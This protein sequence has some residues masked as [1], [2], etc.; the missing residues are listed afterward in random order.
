MRISLDAERCARCK[1]CLRVGENY[2][3][4]WMDD[5][6]YFDEEVCNTC[7]KC[8]A[9]C[10]FQ[11]IVVDGHH[12]EKIAERHSVTADGFTRLLEQRRSTKAFKDEAVPRELL[13]RIAGAAKFS[14]NQNKNISIRIITDKELIREIDRAAIGFVKTMHG[15]LFGCKAVTALIR[16]F[17]R[18]IDVIKR[19]MEFNG[20]KRVIYENAQ[21]VILLVGDRKTPVTESSGHYV[22]A[23]MMYM[24]EVVRVGTCVMD[25]IYLAFRTDRALRK[26]F[27]ITEDVLGAM[28]LGYSAEEIVNVPRGYEL[29]IAWNA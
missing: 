2:C 3:V 5:H 24:A 6:P 21:A 1:K 15:L 27:G 8:V 23:T 9:V 19:K 7:Q 20:F 10:P 12:P 11:A 28:I 4:F 18:D 26:R 22:L 25:S 17:Y 13:E 29:D 16:L 14:P